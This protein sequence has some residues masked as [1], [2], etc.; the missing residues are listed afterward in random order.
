MPEHQ[1]TCGLFN[2]YYQA[3]IHCL[4]MKDD[5]FLSELRQHG[6]LPEN[7]TTTL[8]SL[9]SSAERASYFLETINPSMSSDGDNSLYKLLSVMKNSVLE[10]VAEFAKKIMAKLDDVNKNCEYQSS[11]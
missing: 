11:D 1:S 6:L 5:M 2:Y 9:G 3:F 7:V 4:P 10:N 8:E